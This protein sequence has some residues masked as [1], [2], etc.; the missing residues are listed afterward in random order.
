MDY[1]Y[2][3]NI[4]FT[5]NQAMQLLEFWGFELRVEKKKFIRNIYHNQVEE[6]EETIIKVFKNDKPVLTDYKDGPGEFQ[7]LD[8]EGNKTKFQQ[9]H[10][11][12]KK[13]SASRMFNFF[14]KK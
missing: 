4:Q 2:T 14:F 7:F 9:V 8:L 11:V 13:E 6:F 3:F 12:F 1:N 5:G 10:E